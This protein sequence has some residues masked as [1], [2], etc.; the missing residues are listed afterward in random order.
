MDF[1]LAENG[2]LTHFIEAKLSDEGVS[3][4]LR[5]FKERHKDVKALQL[6]HNAR[7]ERQADGVSVARAGDWL[8]GLSA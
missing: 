4:G 1:A 5:Y 6:V 7:N 3:R 2:A 8:A